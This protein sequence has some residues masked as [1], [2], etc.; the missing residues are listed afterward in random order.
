MPSLSSWMAVCP[1]LIPVFW[2]SDFDTFLTANVNMDNR[3]LHHLFRTQIFIC[4]I[5]LL[6]SWLLLFFMPR[7][8]I[9]QLSL[10]IH[11]K[12]VYDTEKG[13]WTVIHWMQ[14][15]VQEK[16]F[17]PSSATSPLKHLF[18]S[19]I[20]SYTPPDRKYH[21]DHSIRFGS[22]FLFYP[23]KILFRRPLWFFFSIRNYFSNHYQQ[24]SAYTIH[25]FFI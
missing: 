2:V 17:L 16:T 11:K 12:Q 4:K 10:W 15:C 14:F 25:P 22:I 24:N 8:F 13:R 23:W 6:Y 19:D 21:L 7:I 3:T 1:L 20:V 18:S 5:S 9:L